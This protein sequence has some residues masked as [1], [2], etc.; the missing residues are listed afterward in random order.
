MEVRKGK[1]FFIEVEVL[2]R[3]QVHNVHRGGNPSLLEVIRLREEHDVA[4]SEG[5]EIQALL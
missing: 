4:L 5:L 3:S 2:W 1:K